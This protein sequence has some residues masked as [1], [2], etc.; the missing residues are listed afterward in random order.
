MKIDIFKIIKAIARIISRYTYRVKYADGRKAV[1]R[2]RFCESKKDGPYCPHCMEDKHKWI[3]L[4]IIENGM[5][6]YYNC[7]HCGYRAEKERK[8]SKHLNMY[9]D[10]I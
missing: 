1:F 8:P 5:G 7:A 3:S 2:Y 9:S 4:Q 10:I 6:F